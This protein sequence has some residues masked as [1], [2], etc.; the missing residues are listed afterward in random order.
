MTIRKNPGAT[1]W[2]P[3]RR[4]KP[5]ELSKELVRPKARPFSD[6]GNSTTGG[7]QG[8]GL[9]GEKRATCSESRDFLQ[10]ING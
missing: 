3:T 4:D 5:V 7:F 10:V 2:F 1:A 9:H 6:I 8:H